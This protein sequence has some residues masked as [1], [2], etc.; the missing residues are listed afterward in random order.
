MD[1]IFTTHA[2]NKYLY[3]PK[4]S[5]FYYM[6][7]YMENT[8]DAYYQRKLAFWRE[9]GAFEE[10]RPEL[11]SEID[12]E[13]IAHTLANTRQI[14]FEVT[15]SCNLRCEYCF[16]G[17]YYSNHDE[18]VAQNLSVE[19]VKYILD[20]FVKAW[21]S[22]E[23]LSYQNVVGI[24]FY[25]GEALMNFPLIKYI[26]EYLESL[27]VKQMQFSYGMTTNGMLLHKY[28]DFIAKHDFRLLISLD[29]NKRHNV[30]RITP[31]GKNSFDTIYRNA[32]LLRDKYP[33]YFA[34]KV[35]FNAVLNK[36]SDE[37]EIRDFFWTE[38][39]KDVMISEMNLL[40]LNEKYVKEFFNTLFKKKIDWQQLLQEEISLRENKEIKVT[41][42]VIQYAIFIDAYCGNSVFSIQDLFMQNTTAQ[43]LLPTG[44]CLPFDRKIFITTNGKILPCEKIGQDFVLA[45]VSDGGLHIDLAEI[46][47]AYKK[48]YDKIRKQCAVCARWKNCGQCMLSIQEVDGKINC[49]IFTPWNKALDYFSDLLSYAEEHPDLYEIIVKNVVFK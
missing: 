10:A 24:D 25:G 7:P 47:E 4:N 19:K 36:D 11:T 49:P 21:N 9:H 37:K 26:V 43:K 45:Q 17:K 39:K 20:Y 14:L 38:F 33:D 12:R 6:P 8:D 34:K 42:S 40:G 28:M 18:R 31:N 1:K 23:N 3:S 16:Y 5:E 22:D 29:G 41:D 15:D 35:S 32:C 44:T 30:H 2:G 13:R 46:A 27:H 48:K